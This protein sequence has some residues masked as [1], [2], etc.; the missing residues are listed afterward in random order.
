MSD[1]IVSRKLNI[2]LVIFCF[3][4][5]KADLLPVMQY[6]SGKIA[7]NSAELSVNFFV[8]FSYCQVKASFLHCAF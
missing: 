6:V 4:L 2:I 8:D 7:T 5:C 1:C 3:L